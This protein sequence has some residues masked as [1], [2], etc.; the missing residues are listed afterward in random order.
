MFKKLSRQ[1][2]FQQQSPSTIRTLFDGRAGQ[3]IWSPINVL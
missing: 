1:S 3:R 2:R